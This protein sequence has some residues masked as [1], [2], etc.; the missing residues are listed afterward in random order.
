ME[1]ETQI[2]QL[3]H[4]VIKIE[5]V[6]STPTK[7]PVEQ[8]AVQEKPMPT[9]PILQISSPQVTLPKPKEKVKKDFDWIF[10]SKDCREANYLDRFFQK[11]DIEGLDLNFLNLKGDE[12]D[13]ATSEEELQKRAKNLFSM[14]FQQSSFFEESINSIERRYTKNGGNVRP[15]AIDEEE[16]SLPGFISDS[17]KNTRT[18]TA[19]SFL[20]TN[21]DDFT[22]FEGDLAEVVKSEGFKAR[23]KDIEATFTRME[24]EE[25]KKKKKQPPKL[26]REGSEG[27]IN[28]P[29][30]KKP[31][32]AKKRKD[33]GREE[34][35]ITESD[36]KPVKEKK[37]KRPK[38]NKDETQGLPA[39]PISIIQ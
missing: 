21:V 16:S 36:P 29:K 6:E 26:R 38:M 24:L 3:A 13:R 34:I 27:E 37:T 33:S 22:M 19:C 10:V 1:K 11:E 12:W 17:G 25:G 9:H 31:K 8:S 18:K 14:G 39:N 2:I 23:R 4:N 7:E 30:P 20:R 28:A 5:T 15:D 35:T 32:E